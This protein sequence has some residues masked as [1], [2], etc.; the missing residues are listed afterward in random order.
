MSFIMMLIQILLLFASYTTLRARFTLYYSNDRQISNSAFDCIYASLYDNLKEVTE[1]MIHI[2]HLV[3]YCRRPDTDEI[4]EEMDS[5]DSNGHRRI[6]FDELKKQGVTSTQLLTW[7]AP[8]DVAERYEKYNESTHDYFYNCSSPWFGSMCQY[9]FNYDTTKILFEDII[10][11]TFTNRFEQCSNTEIITCYPFVSNCSRVSSSVCLD[12]REICDGKF[13]CIHGEDEEFCEQLEINECKHGEYRCHYGGQCIPLIFLDDGRANIDCLDGSDEIDGGIS[14]SEIKM[15]FSCNSI[16]T[17][18]CEERACRY[19]H[20]LSCGDGQCVS[21]DM[22]NSFDSECFN[23]RHLKATSILLDSS[24]DEI[25]CQ[26]A[27]RCLIRISSNISNTCPW[28][29]PINININDCESLLT[30]CSSVWIGIPQQPQLFGFFQFIYL[31]NRSNLEFENNVMPDYV[32][33]HPQR[34]PGLLPIIVPIEL[35]NGLTCCH[36]SNLVNLSNVQNF[37]GMENHFKDIIRRCLT[38]GTELS[39]S[40]SYLF[41][42]S[43]SLKC[44]SRHRLVDGFRDCYFG[45]DEDY[46]AC[47]LND[48]NRFRCVSNR[49][50]CLSFVAVGNLVSDCRRAEDEL[51]SVER[52]RLQRPPFGYLCN[53]VRETLS[54]I[55]E[56]DDEIHCEKWPCNTPY[57]RC[58]GQWDCHNDVD[59]LNCPGVD[60]IGD[61]HYCELSDRSGS[62]CLSTEHIFEKYLNTCRRNSTIVYREIYF[63]NNTNNNMSEYISW[64]QTRCI[65]ED[66]ICN[67]HSLISNFGDEICLYQRALWIRTPIIHLLSTNSQTQCSTSRPGYPKNVMTAFASSSGLGFFPPLSAMDSFEHIHRIIQT[68]KPEVKITQNSGCNRGI[69]INFRSNQSKCLCPPNYFGSRC[70]WQ[71]QRI[72]LTLRLSFS[73]S[74]LTNIAFQIIIMLMDESENILSTHEQVTFVPIRDCN[75]KFNIYLL[76]P[77]R[78][79]YIFKNY[80]VRIDIF[81]KINL[82]YHA[83]WY[84]S[85]PFQFLPVNRISTELFI[86]ESSYQMKS[87]S[88]QCGDHGQCRKYDNHELLEFCRC[89]EGYSGKFC[90]VTEI[91]FCS[92]DSFCLSSSICVCPIGKFGSQCYLKHETCQISNTSCKNNGFCIPNDDRINRRTLTCLCPE[93]YSGTTCEISNSHINIQFDEKLIRTTS[94][95]L[96]HFITIFNDKNHERTTTFKK[97]PFDQYTIRLYIEQP[98]H[99]LLIE[100]TDKSYYLATVR[101]KFINSENITTQIRTN[102]QCYSIDKLMNS[103]LL[104]YSQF[105]RVKYYPM[106]CRQYKEL[107]CLYDDL[108]ICICDRDRFSNCFEF[109]HRKKYD[110][111]R[112]NLCENNG[113]CFEN[114]VTCPTKTMCVSEDCYYGDK[115]Q[116]STKGFILSL[117]PILGYHIKPNLPIHRQPSIV[118]G[119]IAIVTCLFVFG[120]I[121]ESLSIITFM[122]KTPRLVGCGWYLLASSIVSLCLL[123]MLKIKFWI[124]VLSQQGR[125]TNQSFLIFSCIII[126]ASLNILLASNDW[127]NACVAIER[128]FTIL[129]GV[130]FDI[131]KSKRIAKRLI[132]IVLLIITVTYIHD[133]LYRRLIDDFDT[134]EKRTWCFVRYSSSIDMYN[135]IINLFHF[136]VPVFINF[137]A[138]IIIIVLAARNRS[139]IERNVIFT[140]HFKQQLQQYKHLL[141]GPC[142]IVLL[143]LPRL[144]IPFF[145]GCMK[146]PHD[147]W[148]FLI[149]YFISFIPVMLQFFLF[150]WPSKK[151]MNEMEKAL[152]Q[153]IRWFHLTFMSNS[154]GT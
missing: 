50:K 96:I 147:S 17:F 137:I 112:Q 42:C 14:Y 72:S 150:V 15:R 135:F 41:H 122:M 154:N 142:L 152:Q 33:F 144:I 60:C 97:I 1:P 53:T 104:N 99:I 29:M 149:S 23:G 116:L 5:F 131:K 86:P 2:Y 34:C 75:T 3:P 16:P 70:Q 94:S 105:H 20:S 128:T 73:S 56:Q 4:Q 108:Y 71:N 27:L 121:S 8:I 127:L 64:N 67:R 6:H 63:N 139:I 62:L 49:S 80:S 65:T 85:I 129:N 13:D 133:P 115:C 81:N 106:I 59:E 11:T 88:L 145:S 61:K 12:W 51:V 92:N 109:D 22:I 38:I 24:Y 119:S 100:L 30:H 143:S 66:L 74:I 93:H 153:I 120:S 82:T 44:I 126:D 102:Q 95:V 79:K 107:M 84:P 89:D 101:E 35:D 103:T 146:S 32:C 37:D 136:I 54:D 151:Y 148:V 87:C 130:H 46:P 138:A 19:P 36:I 110:C 77:H 43:R 117:D 91:C 125:I 83:S 52:I 45:E 39:C 113:R 25:H 118:K 26:Q 98:F 7:M 69:V 10:N 48:F 78:P 31:T 21:F 111:Q 9:K 40:Q 124:L 134:E 68:T 123:I 58:D 132:L 141:W 114:N 55:I 57:V 76:Y 47:H 28:S 90:N 140:Q 18:V